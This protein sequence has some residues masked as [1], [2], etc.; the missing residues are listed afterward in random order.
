VIRYLLLLLGAVASPV[1]AQKLEGVW[2]GSGDRIAAPPANVSFPRKVGGL[3][4]NATAEASNKGS[5]LDNTAEYHSADGK[6]WAT[7]YVYRPGY[8]DAAIA[9]YMTDAAIRQTYGSGLKRLSQTVAPIGGQP[10]AAIRMIYSGGV[11]QDSG[12]LASAAAFAHV[13]GWILVLRVSGPVDRAAEVEAALDAMLTATKF[14]SKAYVLPAAPL[15]FAAPCPPAASGTVIPSRSDKSGAN[16]LMAAISASVG[17]EKPKD[18]EL[19]PHFPANG[20]TRV[21]VRGT[22]GDNGLEILQPAGTSAPDIILL[23]LNDVDDVISVHKNLLGEGY[24]LGKAEIGRTL[25]LGE[26]DRMP[27]NDQL[28]RILAG[29]QKELLAIRSS[30]T[31][32]ANGNTSVNIST[33]MLK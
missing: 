1:A 18:D 26:M 24:T 10:N 13:N 16:A 12:P 17:T 30:T 15:E 32:K 23:P 21:C 4:L 29:E 14:D 8:P 25:V 6:I 5:S 3:S 7:I 2:K 31:I 22:F 28:A 9:A 20:L 11:I 33:G 27:D 19:K